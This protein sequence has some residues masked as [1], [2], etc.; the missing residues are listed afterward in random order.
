VGAEVVLHE[1][2]LLGLRKMCIGQIPEQVGEIDGGVAIGYF[3]MPPSLQRRE[4]HEQIGC[5]IPLV[6][7]VM[8]Y[9]LSRLCLDR[10][11]R[12]ADQLP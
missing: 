1:H 12:F 6:L 8:P 4:H 11:A 5:P 3:N 9:G 7:I 2:N 10:N